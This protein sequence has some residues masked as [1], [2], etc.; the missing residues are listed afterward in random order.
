M[1][2]WCSKWSRKEV[3]NVWSLYDFE[4]QKQCEDV[5]YLISK[6]VHSILVW[7][8]SGNRYSSVILRFYFHTGLAHNIFISPL[9]LACRQIVWILKRSAGYPRYTCTSQYSCPRYEFTIICKISEI[10][11][12]N[13]IWLSSSDASQNYSKSLLI[14]TRLDNPQNWWQNIFLSRPCK[15]ENVI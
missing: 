14:W 4:V 9:I 5:L 15:I 7:K 1:T 6:R 2:Y 12:Y 13:P 3:M 10:H 8:V 11:M